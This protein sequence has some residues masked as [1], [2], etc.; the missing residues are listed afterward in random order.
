MGRDHGQGAGLRGREPPR[1][2]SLAPLTGRGQEFYPEERMAISVMT[3][4]LPR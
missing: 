2:G 4:V 3:W 1:F